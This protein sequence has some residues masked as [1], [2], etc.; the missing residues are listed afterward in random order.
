MEKDLD[1]S[2]RLF[3]AAYDSI[4]WDKYYEQLK[5]TIFYNWAT[6]RQVIQLL[7]LSI[8]GIVVRTKTLN[9]TDKK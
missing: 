2:Q 5:G 8:P 3:D 4:N 7:K 1:T 9:R 6:K